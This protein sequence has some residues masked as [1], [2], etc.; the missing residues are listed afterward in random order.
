MGTFF[1]YTLVYQSGRL[2][3]FTPSPNPTT[4]YGGL[5]REANALEV[6]RGQPT[7]VVYADGGN[8]FLPEN[9]HD[10]KLLAK[11]KVESQVIVQALNLMSLDVFSPGPTDWQLGKEHLLKLSKQ[12]AFK[13]V[14]TNVMDEKDKRIFPAFQLVQ[15]GG[16]TFAFLSLLPEGWYGSDVH[17]T[18]T[19]SAL[20]KWVW[21]ASVRA[22]FVIVLSQLGNVAEDRKILERYPQVKMVIGN[23]PR[24]ALEVP[25]W[26]RG[27]MLLD[28][29]SRGVFLG[30]MTFEV[31]PPFFG[32]YS[33]PFLSIMKSRRLEVE[34]ELAAEENVERRSKLQERL[35]AI[36]EN[37]PEERPSG[38][39]RFLHDLVPLDKERF[40]RPNEVTAFLDPSGPQPLPE[41]TPNPGGEPTL[42]E[43]DL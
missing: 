5:D 8:L 10:E 21:Q 38:A 28:G 11:F 15:R 13:F 39:S 25:E 41:T 7:M 12:A 17:A 18:S 9:V 24:R 33:E 3:T 27:R 43:S 34:R 23:D 19:K 40:G 16:L 29:Y 20:N 35:T 36:K 2:G 14:S 6:M 30:K 22:D 26:V 31:K 32:F 37:H 1:P 4:P 42:S